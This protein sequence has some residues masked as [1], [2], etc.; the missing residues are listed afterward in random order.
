MQ[1][2]LP[3]LDHL[4]PHFTGDGHVL[5]NLIFEYS[6]LGVLITDEN[7]VVLNC[8]GIFAE[9]TGR[10]Y[11]EILGQDVFSVFDDRDRIFFLEQ[12]RKL[13]DRG[14]SNIQI[15]K[16]IHNGGAAK[17]QKWVQLTCA[18]LDESRII[19]LVR[20]IDD[21]KLR[22]VE[23]LQQENNFKYSL[24]LL[25][26]AYLAFD[27]NNRLK[28]ASDKIYDIFPEIRL[29]LRPDADSK[30]IISKIIYSGNVVDAID[31]EANMLSD[32]TV[33][34]ASQQRQFFFKHRNKRYYLLKIC[35][36]TDGTICTFTDVT[37]S[38][39]KDTLVATLTSE[40]T[41]LSEAIQS[42]DVGIIICDAI[43]PDFPITFVNEAFCKISGYSPDKAVAHNIR[44]LFGDESDG[45]A[46]MNI[47]QC[48]ANGESLDTE[49]KCYRLNKSAFWGH[50]RIN[51]IQSPN[52]TVTHFVLILTDITQRKIQE[53]EIIDARNAAFESNKAKSEF[54]AVMSHEIKTPI[55]GVMGMLQLLLDTGMNKEQTNFLQTAS[56]SAQQ[57]LELVQDILD[58]TNLET[59]KI[60]TNS[61]MLC[62]NDT[63]RRG[64]TKLQPE[65]ARKG[66]SLEFLAD[67]KIPDALFG[68]PDRIIQVMNNIV[69]N[70]IKFTDK[71]VIEI[72]SKL[73]HKGEKSSSVEISIADTGIGI[74]PNKI[75]HIFD[76]FHQIDLSHK[77]KYSGTGLGLAICKKLSELMGGR[78]TAQSM[79][80]KG[81]LFK[82][83][84]TLSHQ[85]MATDKFAT[86]DSDPNQQNSKK[87]KILIVDDSQ[88]NRMVVASMIKNYGFEI[89]QAVDG[90][91]AYELSCKQKFDVIVMDIAM[92]RM[93]GITASKK[94]KSIDSY[95][96][97]VPIIALTAHTLSEERKQCLE[98]G[99]DEYLSKPTDKAQLL[100]TIFHLVKPDQH[101]ILPID[102]GSHAG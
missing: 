65:V 21:E 24:E 51:P 61:K 55:N 7:H 69:G 60:K 2:L 29:A 23:N 57:L 49:I 48:F 56:D 34:S 22:I 68:D 3:S 102:G 5:Q 101:N 78:I 33:E 89:T 64:L 39:E 35:R 67:P 10:P 31:N 76:P 73:L 47:E 38:R 53:Q 17:K 54:L 19:Y 8:N 52:Q 40:N 74:P 32:W 79:P 11:S 70:A 20:D 27:G 85:A 26:D 93:D 77:R 82:W 44:I 9:W 59:K 92:P 46:V 36:L 43:L 37:G 25:A 94:I 28:T 72:Q 4:L 81:S 88:S 86:G 97:R 14:K 6:G 98:S 71:G 42:T 84:L 16:I 13:L 30:E 12:M 58:Y 63:L 95:Y 100:K 50:L 96:K 90:Q 66:L 18:L 91:D 99:M 80:G 83:A 45:K 15:E 75:A 87:I 41:Q 62:L 1:S